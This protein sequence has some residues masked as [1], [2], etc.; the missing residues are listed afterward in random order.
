MSQINIL[1]DPLPETISI[2]GKDYLINS[3]F[4]TFMLLEQLLFDDT[5]SDAD[6]VLQMMNLIFVDEYPS[7]SEEVM[8]KIIEFYRCGKSVRKKA[9]RRNN[10]KKELKAPK[11]YDFDYDDALIFAAFYQQ[12]HIDMNEIED[13]HWWK[14]KALFNSLSAD[15]EFVKIMGYRAA[16]LSQIHDKEERERIAKLKALYSLPSNLSTDEK[17]KRIGALFGG[18]M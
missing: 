14:F 13:M 8:S 1:I 3:G 6:K 2:A 18:G 17:A 15:C 12:Y 10:Q 7:V 4:R 5:I 9:G 16:D 11:I